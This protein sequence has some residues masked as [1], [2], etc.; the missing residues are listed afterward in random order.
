VLAAEMAQAA[1]KGRWVAE[2]AMRLGDAAGDHRLKARMTLVEAYA[3]VTAGSASPLHWVVPSDL[4]AL[5]TKQPEI[6]LTMLTL[7][8]GMTF[9]TDDDAARATA[10][11][12]ARSIPG[13]GGEYWRVYALATSDAV[14]SAA[15]IRPHLAA[16]RESTASHLPSLRA[17]AL[18][19]WHIDE[20]T[21]TWSLLDAAVAGT[22]RDGD[23]SRL[24]THLAVQGFAACW[25][26][27]WLEARD[28][29][30]E[31]ASLAEAVDQPLIVGMAR[32]LDASMAALAGEAGA[33]HVHADRAVA[34]CG[35]AVVVALAAWAR[36]LAELGRGRHAAAWEHMRELT[37]G[38]RST[39]RDVL[40]WAIA[41]LVEVA[42][43]AA[44]RDE[45]AALRVLVERI[46]QEATVSAIGRLRL[47]AG[48]ALALM[49]ADDTAD[50]RFGDAL[51]VDGAADWPFE[52]A[53]TRLAHGEWLRRRRR[54]I[55]ARTSL[56][57]A[58][59]TF[60]RLGAVPWCER[61]RT[62]LRAAGVS[63]EQRKLAVEQTTPESLTPQQR[64]IVGLAAEGLTNRE[65]A[66][67]LFLSPR[68]VGFHLYGAYPKLGV[69]SRAQLAR[70][71]SDG[72]RE[73][74]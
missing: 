53:R 13:S 20:A 30:A 49:A 34:A 27:R 38:G 14:G 23:V 5:V 28:L 2:L 70:L 12:A 25:S 41:D 64:Q 32:A 72:A 7:L 35:Q 42:R 6:G 62:E 11:R 1:G 60:E 71:M 31:A 57:S 48:R 19:H 17:V 63:I 51:A 36:G 3:A 67:R 74:R 50:T 55:D 68:T 47:V 9:A 65:I 39:H 56:R 18:A 29:A 4:G 54:I 37:P 66:E 52:L 69:S 46:D 15:D 24:P 22:R 40:R 21:H 61:A 73:L 26:G 10:Q 59:D 8:A 58:L 33:A 45:Q 44:D 43:R 16:L